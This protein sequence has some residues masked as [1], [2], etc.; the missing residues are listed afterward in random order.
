MLDKRKF[1]IK[2]L[3]I[4]CY[5]NSYNQLFCIYLK[6]GMLNIRESTAPPNLF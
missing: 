5:S 4:K 2:I 3:K 6:Q 1:K